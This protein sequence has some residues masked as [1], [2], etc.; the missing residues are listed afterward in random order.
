GRGAPQDRRGCAICRLPPR[1][2]AH[3]GRTAI[4]PGSWTGTVCCTAAAAGS[5]EHAILPTGPG[6]TWLE[7]SGTVP[8]HNRVDSARP[9]CSATVSPPFG[10]NVQ[11]VSRGRLRRA[12]GQ[13]VE[14]LANSAHH[15]PGGRAFSSVEGVSRL[16]CRVDADRTVRPAIRQGNERRNRTAGTVVP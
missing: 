14:G 5:A 13:R 6:G 2:R 9:A 7:C 16:F 4:S 3:C 8:L 15:R 1:S 11:N 10:Q 12:G